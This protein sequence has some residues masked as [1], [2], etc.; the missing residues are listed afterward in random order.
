MCARAIKL[1]TYIDDWLQKEIAL[2]STSNSA[3]TEDTDF[4]PRDLKRLRLSSTE[5][6]H[7]Q[8]ITDML[9]NFKSATNYLSENRKPQVQFIWLMYNR[10]FDFLDQMIEGLGEDSENRDIEWPA[11]VKGA[12]EKG[13]AK[14]SK[15]YSK[16]DE[17]R[18]YLFNCATILDA[19][20]KLTAYED[21]S[22]EAHDKHMYRQQFLNYLDRYDNHGDRDFTP[23]A[24]GH[25]RQPQGD[26]WFR[27]PPLLV[28]SQSSGMS[29]ASPRAASTLSQDLEDD[30]VGRTRKQGEMYLSVPHD[31]GSAQFNILDWWRDNEATYPNLAQVA[32]DILPVQIAGVGVERVFNTSKDVIGDRRHRLSAQTI[33]QIMILKH[34]LP[35]EVE[36]TTLVDDEPAPSDE[37]DDL[38]ELPAYVT[39]PAIGIRIEEE[40]QISS[41]SDEELPTPSTRVER[42]H[43][44]PRKRVRPLRYRD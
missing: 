36:P 5:W 4:T 12:A 24:T 31:V 26:E 35:Q 32:R 25:V 38:F 22:W 11:I 14:L 37:V 40:I 13:R 29:S 30:T 21:D 2:N 28:R 33:Q 34:A 8:L 39:Q 15:Y 27:K 44:P 1:R 20:Q 9:Q 19:S 3:S 18:G 16:T 6:H 42:D 41:D 17:E 23:T 10:L 43:P 7:L